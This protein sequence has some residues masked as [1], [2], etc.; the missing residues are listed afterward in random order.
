MKYTLNNNQNQSKKQKQKLSFNSRCCL[1]LIPSFLGMIVFFI[2]PYLRVLYYS[3]IDNQFRKNFIWFHNYVTTL[4]NQ[5]FQ[6]AMKNS[7]LLIIIGVPILIAL[8]IIL[9]LALAFGLKRVPKLRDA[10]IFPMLIPT[11]G[12]VLIWQQLFQG[13][14]TALPIYLLFIW[15]NIGIC[16]ILLTAAIT[17][18][19]E[20][21]FEAAKMD[22]AKTVILHKNITIPM[23]SPTIF[24]TV[25]LSI[26][27]SFKI[28]K[29]SYLYYGN[30]YPPDYSYTLQF[31]M[32]NNFLK[33][34]YQSL[35]TSSILTSLIVFLIIIAGLWMQRRFQS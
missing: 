20:S 12:I 14:A 31:Y 15:K 27:N 5:Y 10:F 30:K 33:F 9:S 7:L 26:V 25:L 2:I 16:I 17:T 1:C 34:D 13:F 23:L 8:A 22:G 32:N 4:R 11:A 24:F 19:E 35:A 3:F 6:L 18:M 28:F 21:V 29:E